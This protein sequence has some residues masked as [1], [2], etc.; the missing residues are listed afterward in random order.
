MIKLG[1][2]ANAPIIL[3]K[4]L[5]IYAGII[6]GL[7]IF[8]GLSSVLPTLLAIVAIAGCVLLHEIGHVLAGRRVGVRTERIT[9]N[10]FGGIAEPNP[11]DWHALMDRPKDAIFV[12]ICGPAVNLAII[13]LFWPI[14][15]GLSALSWHTLANYA[16]FVCM[17]NAYMMVFNLLPLFPLDGG[18]ILYSILRMFKPKHLAIRVASVVSMV[19]S[20]LLFLVAIYFK[21]F[22]AAL[23]AA[24]VF[25]QA[26][27]A[28]T[29]GLFDDY[30]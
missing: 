5:L 26:K 28:P 1:K 17:F 15:L 20:V 22:V 7:N 14:S 19:G 8:D 27:K 18:G 23:I 12:W 3:T 10:F 13:C 9:L 21:L 11:Y 16:E 29:S 25:F 30:Y 24:A 4:N 2:V 6:T